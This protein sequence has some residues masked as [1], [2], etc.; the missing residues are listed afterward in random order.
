VTFRELPEPPFRDP[1]H[2][3]S[4]SWTPDPPAL[5]E[6]AAGWRRRHAIPLAGED[7]LDLQ[8]LVV[9]GQRD[10]CL[11]EGSLYVGGRSGTG[12][13]DDTRRLVSWIY[14][15]L[16][17]VT[18]V[19]ATLDSHL[20]YQIFFPSF[21]VDEAGMPLRA[22]RVVSAAEV[23]AGAVR[24]HPAVAGWICGGDAEWLRAEVL[25][26]CE[27]LERQ[28]RYRLYLWPPHCLVGGPGH[29]F[30]G[31][32]QEALLFHAWVRC[33]ETRLALK[34]SDPLT[35]HYSALRP[36]VVIRHDGTRG[37]GVDRGL[38]DALLSADA[39]VVAG[40]ASSHCVRS[41]VEDLLAEIRRRDPAL[42]RRV[43]LLEDCMSPV[44][45]P[46]G[47]GGFV[48]DFTEEAAA[49]LR[50]FAQAGMCVVRS[51]LPLSRW[52]GLGSP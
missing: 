6:A 15:N 47:K 25:H 31:S 27:A 16:A 50:G 18:R 51:D 2:D 7:G 3:G 37:A 33:A 39:L 20:P 41:T 9:D 48:A 29:A 1:A 35:E 36:E 10:F 13:V 42:A 21:W 44:A 46:D 5:L 12:A 30:V 8:L 45:V 38:V 22:H 43:Y 11:P 14:R 49:A 34:G 52:P 28:G 26:Y 4:W 23:R 19:T 32:I 24:P 40:Q 17:H